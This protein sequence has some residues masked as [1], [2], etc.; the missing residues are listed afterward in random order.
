GRPAK[1]YRR[2]PRQLDVTLPRRRYELAGR[3]LAR[4]L[5]AVPARTGSRVLD[6][7]AG[8]A[9]RQLGAAARA[10][11]RGG[12][13]RASA[14]ARAL[15]VLDEW[16]Y[17]PARENGTVRL[18]NCPFEALANDCRPLVCGMNLS[19]VRGLL[20]GLGTRTL[21]AELRPEPGSC[22]VVLRTASRR[23]LHS[24]YRRIRP[25]RASPSPRPGH[26]RAR[27]AALR[28]LVGRPRMLLAAS[29][30][31][32]GPVHLGR[33]GPEALLHRRARVGH[34]EADVDLALAAHGSTASAIMRACAATGESGRTR[35]RSA[36][37]ESVMTRSASPSAPLSVRT[38]SA[39]WLRAATV[40]NRPM[41]RSAVLRGAYTV[42]V[43]PADV[44][45]GARGAALQASPSAAAAVR[46]DTARRLAIACIAFISLRFYP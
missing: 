28:F 10:D 42:T 30:A 46:L 32:L 19:L 24:P 35:P 14:L 34:A 5:A 31:L 15:A 36:P 6:R 2:A 18:R 16:G 40:C 23:T 1:L 45:D 38:D 4:A 8:G 22:C 13:R 9:G 21:R 27:R 43:V 39:H 44:R 20:Q 11:A 17:E 3:V 29:V 7:V 37:P 33:R 12:A 25:R 41:I 26:V